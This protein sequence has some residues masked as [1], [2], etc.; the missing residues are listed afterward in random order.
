MF[1]AQ[2]RSGKVVL[3]WLL[4]LLGF[5]SAQRNWELVATATLVSQ[6]HF[7]HNHKY[8]TIAFLITIKTAQSQPDPSVAFKRISVKQ[9]YAYGHYSLDFAYS[10][11]VIITLAHADLLLK[12]NILLDDS[13]VPTYLTNMHKVLLD[14]IISTTE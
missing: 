13:T 3:S 5:N 10:T 11:Y 12:I 1:K 9:T 8:I 2:T 6:T 4:Q 7:Y 14:F